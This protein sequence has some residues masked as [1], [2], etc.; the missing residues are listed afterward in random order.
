MRPLVRIPSSA[1]LEPEEETTTIR[2]DVSRV[3]LPPADKAGVAETQEDIAMKRRSRLQKTE[4]RPIS[5]DSDSTTR[6]SS[7]PIGARSVGGRRLRMARGITVDSGAADPVMPRRMVRRRGNNI[8]SS[9]ASRAGV[10]YVSATANRIRNEGETD[11]HFDTE[12]GQKLSWTFQIAAVSK[13]RVSPIPCR[14]QSL[15]RL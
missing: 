13:V 5:A 12:A 3:V 1:W 11:C 14:P 6:P 8:R 10:H 4:D 2:Q 7:R 15:S 9:Q